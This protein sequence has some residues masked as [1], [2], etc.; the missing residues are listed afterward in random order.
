MKLQIYKILV[1]AI[2]FSTLYSCN[3]DDENIESQNLIGKYSGTFTVE[4]LNGNNFSNSV[5]VNFRENSHYQSSGNGNQHNFYPA[6]GSGTYEIEDS[7]ITFSDTNTWLAHFDWNLILTGEYDY[8][9]N[10]NQLIISA[11]KNNVGF[12]K[13]ELVKE[14]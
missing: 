4:Y 3:N 14:Q 2:I 12:Y 6:G 7:K 9:I 1:I 13:Y 10:G 5:T 11:N 8:T